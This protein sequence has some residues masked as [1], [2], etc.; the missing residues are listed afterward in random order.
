MEYRKTNTLSSIKIVSMQHAINPN[1]SVI[2]SMPI[3][4]I[5][6]WYIKLPLNKCYKKQNNS[7]KQ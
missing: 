3:K 2:G 1:I 4:S 5:N 7:T 6:C